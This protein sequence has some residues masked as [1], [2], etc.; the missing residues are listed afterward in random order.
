MQFAE[1]NS[2]YHVGKAGL[3]EIIPGLSKGFT[4]AGEW[5]DQIY[6]ERP[7]YLSTE[8][9][10]YPV[11]KGLQEYKIDLPTI[12]T[13]KLRA[14]LPSL[15]DSGMYITEDAGGW[16]EEGQEPKVLEFYLN[17]DGEVSL[18][19]LS[20]LWRPAMNVTGTVAYLGTIPLSGKLS[21]LQSFFKENG[22][23]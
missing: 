23:K 19:R 8:T 5:A 17:E 1:I 18:T 10:R 16:W 4:D 13:K 12:D 2:L 15:V 22:K 21:S 7:A 6:R 9:G 3:S 20:K 14:D 11:T